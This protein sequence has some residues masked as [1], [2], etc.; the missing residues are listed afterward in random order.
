VKLSDN[1]YSHTD[2]YAGSVEE[3]VH[4]F[5]AMLADKEV[6]MLMFGGGEVCNEILPYIDYDLAVR[7]PK[8]ICSYS[9]STT[10]LNVL[11][12]KTGLV[13]FYG[14]S[15]RTFD[16]LTDYNL[17]AFQSR[18]TGQS[19]PYEK[20][21]EWRAVR[22]GYAEGVLIGG[23]LVNFAVMQNGKY[24]SLDRTGKYL[25][26]IED[27]EKFSS[28]AVVSKYFSHLEQ[29]GLIE[30]VTGLIFGHYA[31]GDRPQIDGVLARFGARHGIPVVRNDDFGHGANNTILPI[32]VPAAL[33]ADALTFALRES[34]V[35]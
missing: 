11:Y 26:F 13:T 23:Y 19:V 1:F 6:K 21:G 27:H 35:V 30:S 3:R 2:G 25:L 10:I 33:D 34:G 22:G 32:G 17:R 9:D 31:E 20:G 24:F 16:S 29:S 12:A 5:N 18:L 15:P 4:D 28:P 7:N 14:A 8:I